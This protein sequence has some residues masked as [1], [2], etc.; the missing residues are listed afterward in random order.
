MALTSVLKVILAPAIALTFALLSFA[1]PTEQ[2]IEIRVRIMDSRTHRP[3]KE[4]KIQITFSGVDGEWYHNATI[5]TTNTGPDGVAVFLV[6]QP[7]PP[8][9]DVIDLAGYPCSRPEAFHTQ[10]ILETGIVASWPAS[11]IRKADQWCMPGPQVAQPQKKRGKLYSSFIH[12]IC[13][14]IFG[15]HS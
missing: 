9:I 4:R 12:L 1:M 5:M 13:G 8:K 2:P 14:K 15:T 10:E 11:G 6:K 7:I 3:L